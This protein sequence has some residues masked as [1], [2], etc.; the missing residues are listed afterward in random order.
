MYIIYIINYLKDAEY[1]CCNSHNSRHI[2]QYNSN[3]L[4]FPWHEDLKSSRMSVLIQ[5]TTGAL[6]SF[7]EIMF[8]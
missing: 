8:N 5:S 7:P 6:E 3:I 4:T 2:I 1:Q